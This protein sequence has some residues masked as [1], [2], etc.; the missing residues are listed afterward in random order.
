MAVITWTVKAEV[1]G[2]P[3]FNKATTLNVEAYE[4]IDVVIPGGETDMEVTVDG[5]GL[6]F[7]AIRVEQPATLPAQTPLSYK[8]NDAGADAIDLDQPVQ[9]LVGAGAVGLLGVNDL[10]SLFITNT[11]AD[12]ATVSILVGRDATP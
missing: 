3:S 2:G 8:V 12:N 10:D 5:S 1:A 9:L 6:Q 4:K 7:L 11:G